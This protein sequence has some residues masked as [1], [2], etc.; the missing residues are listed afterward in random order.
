MYICYR[1]GVENQ[2]YL[3]DTQLADDFHVIRAPA[4]PF[5]RLMFQ[6]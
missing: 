5:Q 3:P 4:L 1:N 2:I 6:V